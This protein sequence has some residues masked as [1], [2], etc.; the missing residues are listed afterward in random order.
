MQK[1]WTVWS[2]ALFLAFVVVFSVTSCAKKQITSKGSTTS[3]EDARIRADEDVNQKAFDS[4]E[5]MQEED[6]GDESLSRE[7]ADQQ[8]ASARSAFENEDIYFDFDSTQLSLDAQEVL[9]RKANWLRENP[10]ATITIEGHC[11]SRGTNEYNL[12]LG[13]GRAESVKAFLVDLGI[14]PYRMIA[15][16]YGEE[17]PIDTAQTEEAWAR[18]RRAHFVIDQ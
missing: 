13:E 11:D 16:S 15:I 18:N 10:E 8:A 17:R 3:E 9:S 14:K 6:L 2:L 7:M 4:P 12:A 1:K 5:T